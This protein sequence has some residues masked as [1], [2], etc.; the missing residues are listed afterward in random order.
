MILSNA[1]CQKAGSERIDIHT[2]E[3]NSGASG[4]GEHKVAQDLAEIHRFH[5]IN[6]WHPRHKAADS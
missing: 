3:R 1:R 5:H 4:L 6:L 2:V